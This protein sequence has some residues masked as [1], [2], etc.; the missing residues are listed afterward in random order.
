M[1]EQLVTTNLADASRWSLFRLD[2]FLAASGPYAVVR[3]GRAL[4]PLRKLTCTRSYP[5]RAQFAP[6]SIVF[7]GMKR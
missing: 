6:G 1:K 5:E 4:C 2:A 7:V 3:V